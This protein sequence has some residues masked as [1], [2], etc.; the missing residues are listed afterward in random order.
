[1][2]SGPAAPT[3]S[4]ILL[5]PQPL[6]LTTDAPVIHLLEGRSFRL[7]ESLHF[8]LGPDEP[9]VGNVN[10]TLAMM[11]HQTA[12]HWREWVRG[13]AIPLEWQTVVIRAAITLKLCQHE[14]TGAIVA[15][16]TTS[17]PEA[18]AFAAATGTIAIA[19][20]A[21]LITPSRR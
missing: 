15:A 6:R 9:F 1:M 16:L 21:T 19:G 11:L 3:T 5:E 10:Q 4:A 18:R 14:E 8:F 17:I 12:E 13:L 20:S 2:P 7:E